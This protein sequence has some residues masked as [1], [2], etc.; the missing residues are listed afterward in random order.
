MIHGS[1]TNNIE[2]P[3]RIAT[4]LHLASDAK[5]GTARVSA[6]HK[7]PT[8]WATTAARSWSHSSV[9]GW[10]QTYHRGAASQKRNTL[11]SCQKNA[12]FMESTGSNTPWA[13]R[14]HAC[15]YCAASILSMKRLACTWFHTMKATS[16]NANRDVAITKVR[17][18]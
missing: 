16:C 4:R 1:A 10:G 15:S 13:M 8:H 12:F 14:Y 6:I 9:T 3:P 17:R 2:A 5:R 18:R 11:W 7:S